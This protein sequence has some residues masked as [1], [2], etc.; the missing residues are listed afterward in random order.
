MSEQAKELDADIA[1]EHRA[2]DLTRWANLGMGL[3]GALAAWASNSQALLID[4]LFSLIGYISAVF[5]M[6]ISQTAHLGPDRLRPFGHASDEALYATFRSLALIGLVVFGVFQ[7][8]L[9]IADYVLGGDVEEVRL[10]PVAIYAVIV[11]VACFWLAYVH[12]RAWIRT[13]KQSDM[14]KLE[15][16]AS[17]YDGVITLFAGVALLSTPLLA[18]TIFEPLTPVMDSIVV[19]FLCSIAVFGYLRAFWKGVAQLAGVPANAKDQL[20]VRHAI[21]PIAKDNGG[22]VLDVALVRVGRKLDAVVY[23]RPSAPVTAEDVD[24]IS[25]QMKSQIEKDIGPVEVLV[26]V[27]NQSHSSLGA[28]TTTS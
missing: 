23:Y 5:A 26:A 3:A 19:L 14:L 20:A 28:W 2:M 11:T 18:D 4:G 1:V 12:K 7:A 8:V 13:G 21:K 6:R 22:E 25:L 17:I 10:L 27:S 16:T 9:G 15:A 24:R